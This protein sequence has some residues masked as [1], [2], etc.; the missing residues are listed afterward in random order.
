[1][2]PKLAKANAEIGKKENTVFARIV[3]ADGP[4]VVNVSVAFPLLPLTVIGLVLPKEQEGAGVTAG[5]TLQESVTVP[6]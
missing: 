5:A 3:A 2:K 4:T 6:V 1:M